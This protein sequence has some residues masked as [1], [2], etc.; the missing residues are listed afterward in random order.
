MP[1][2]AVIREGKRYPDSLGVKLVGGPVRSGVKSG[3][4]PRSLPIPAD[5]SLVRKVEFLV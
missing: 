3:A 2:A 4:Q 5:L 1:A